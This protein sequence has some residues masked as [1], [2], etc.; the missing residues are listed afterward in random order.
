MPSKSR[1][2]PHTDSII[3]CLTRNPIEERSRSTYQVSVVGKS[4]RLTLEVIPFSF[5][6]EK[7]ERKGARTEGAAPAAVGL[8]RLS[9]MATP[10]LVA[11]AGSGARKRRPWPHANVTMNVAR[12]KVPRDAGDPSANYTRLR[13]PA[14]Q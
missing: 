9:F 1:K 7:R 13:E 12:T 2:R 6:D 10:F 5:R 8:V 4:S 3:R 11:P 14:F